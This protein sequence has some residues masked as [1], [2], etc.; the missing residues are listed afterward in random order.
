MD[1]D[2]CIMPLPTIT[3]HADQFQCPK[4]AL[5][6]ACL[7]LFILLSYPPTKLLANTDLSNVSKVLLLKHHI[8]GITQDAIFLDWFCLPKNAHVTF[9][10]VFSYLDSSFLSII[11]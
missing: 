3:V 6:P 2:K 5:F 10:F 8:V 11:K 9:L 7:F 4:S 1:F